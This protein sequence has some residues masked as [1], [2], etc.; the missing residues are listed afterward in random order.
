MIPDQFS[1]SSP[2]KVKKIVGPSFTYWA[3]VPNPLPPKLV[4]DNDLLFLLGEANRAMG[5]FSGF[6]S[7]SPGSRLL[8]RPLFR[9]EA[10]ASSQIEGTTSDIEDLYFFE[11]DQNSVPLADDVRE[12]SNYLKAL[13]YGL[14]RLKSLPISTRLFK[15]LHSV[16]MSGVRGGYSYPGELRR[17]QNWIGKPGCTLNE[18]DYVPP[19]PEELNDCLG[20]LENFI[21]SESRL[22]PLVRLALVHYQFEAI[23]PFVDGNGRVG[24]LLISL[25]K[26]Y[27]GLMDQPGLYLSGYFEANRQEYYSR[28]RS[29]SFEGDWN[30]WIFFFLKAVLQQSE[31]GKNKLKEIMDLRSNWIG[32]LK[33]VSSALPLALIDSLFENPVITIPLAAERLN[34]TYV[35]ARRA[36]TALCEKGVLSQTDQSKYGKKYIASELIEIVK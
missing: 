2:G 36:I 23:H 14:E 28:L 34:V 12:V 3:F 25:L 4:Y 20:E 17:T 13:E 8:I 21:N 11:A 32:R 26:T 6:L 35:S 16:L 15:E 1:S 29:V 5:E 31:L 18:A 27:W 19:P 33:P 30:G 22:P 10:V 9:R 24:R 7:G